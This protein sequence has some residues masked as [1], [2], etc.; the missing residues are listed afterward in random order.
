[1]SA[2]RTAP[3]AVPPVTR[4]APCPPQMPWEQSDAAAPPRAAPPP[5]PTASPIHMLLLR[6]AFVLTD[7]RMMLCRSIVRAPVPG[8]TTREAPVTLSNL[9]R[10]A[11]DFGRATRISVPGARAWT[12][13]QPAGDCAAEVATATRKAVNT[14]TILRSLAASNSGSCIHQVQTRF[15]LVVLIEGRKPR[16]HSHLFTIRM[17]VPAREST[18]RKSYRY[19]PEH[20]SLVSRKG[21]R[22]PPVPLLNR[23]GEISMHTTIRPMQMTDI[24]AG[25]DLCR[26]SRWNQLE[27]DWRFSWILQTVAAGLPNAVAQPSARWRF[28]V[29]AA[30]AGCR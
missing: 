14:R 17:E 2:P 6:R 26:L 13:L 28:C 20:C 11:S 9:P 22:A 7:K 29:M 25:L 23:R 1:M 3:P 21:N 18:G 24:Q 30:L 4:A 16:S 15:I 19:P 12:L 8:L 5:A 27:E 10:T